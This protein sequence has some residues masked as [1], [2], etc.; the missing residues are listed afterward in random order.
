MYYCKYNA[1]CYCMCKPMSWVDCLWDKHA[2]HH[3][4]LQIFWDEK[5]CL[6]CKILCNLS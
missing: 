5:T 6:P 3:K 2:I 4:M 1:M